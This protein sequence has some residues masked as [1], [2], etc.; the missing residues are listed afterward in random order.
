MPAHENMAI[1]DWI[2]LPYS[3]KNK[4]KSM[5]AANVFKSYNLT[6]LHI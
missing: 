1:H 6:R 4:V 2:T 5:T 3:Y